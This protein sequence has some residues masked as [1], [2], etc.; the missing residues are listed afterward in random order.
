MVTQAYWL[1][2]GYSFLEEEQHWVFAVKLW[3]IL[4]LLGF[5]HVLLSI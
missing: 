2:S 1:G 5:D 4:Q 3:W